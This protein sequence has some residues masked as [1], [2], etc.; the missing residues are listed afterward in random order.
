MQNTKT[1]LLLI[2]AFL[3]LGCAR[4]LKMIPFSKVAPF[5]G[6]HMNETSYDYTTAKSKKK[7]K[8]ISHSIKIMSKYT[9]WESQCLVKAIAGMM[10]LERRGIDSTIYLGTTR[11][12]DGKMIAHAWL[13]SGPFYVSGSEGMK[14]F[15]VVGMFAKRVSSNRRRGKL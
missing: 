2:E 10:M 6:D 4:I 7:I 1:K 13:R 8:Q 9:L 12:E 11:D 15:T 5:L 14:Q 3:F